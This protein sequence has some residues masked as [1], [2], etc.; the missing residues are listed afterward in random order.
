M[1]AASR[2][3]GHVRSVN[4][5]VLLCIAFLALTPSLIWSQAT[6]ATFHGTVI[7]PKGGA[8]PGATVTLT[9]ENTGAAKVTTTGDSGD[10]VFTFVPASVY[11][12]R[13]ELQGF[14][15]YT[16]RGILLRAGQQARQTVTLEVGAITEEV[17]VQGGV[18]LVNTVS[19]EQLQTFETQQV[20]ELPLQNRNFTRILILNAGAVPSTGSA[21]GFNMN[22]VGTNG[23]QW[24]LDGTSASGN[25][26]ANS[27]GAYEA[28]NL[29][30]IASQEGIAEV[31]VVKGAIPAEYANA[32]GGQVNVISKSGTNVWHGSVFENHRNDALNARFQR[33]SDKPALTFNQFGG[34]LGG[35]IKKDTIFV[36]GDYEGYREDE[37]AFVQGNVP[38]E[39]LRAQLLDAVPAY[40]LA[41]DAFP[42]PNEPTEPGEVVGLFQTAKPAERR[43]NHFDI[44]G[45]V[46]LTTNHRLAVTYNHGRP[47]RSTPRI[48]IDDDRTWTNRMDRVSASYTITATHWVSETRLG[49]N[50]ATQ[51]RTDGFFR[52][53]DPD[54]PEE[55]FLGARRL[56]RISTTLGFGGPDAEI[57]RSGGPAWEISQKFAYRLGRHLLK[58]GS[59]VHYVS[60]TR[61]NPEIP[62][63]FYDSLEALLENRPSDVTVTLG[64]GD[65]STRAY[66]FGFFVQDDWRV[67]P[68]LTLNAGLRYDFYSNWVSK[69]KGGTPD[70]GL[71]NPDSLSQDG[72]FTVGRFRPVS[73]PFEHD[74]LNL[75][76]RLGFAYN[77][78]GRGRTA[79]RGGFSMM[80]TRNTPEI[81][82]F[83]TAIARNVPSRFEFEP[84]LIRRFEIRYPTFN[85]EFFDS[86]LQLSE[87]SDR[88]SVFQMFDSHLESPY[89]MQYTFDIQRQLTPTLMFSTGVVGTRGVKF[90]LFRPANRV[91]R[92]TGL[93]PNPDLSEVIWTDNSQSLT[94]YAWQSS[95]TKRFSN[96][97]SFTV[98]YTWSKG[99]SNGAGDFGPWFAGENSNGVNQE[100]FDTAADRG[101]T[102]FDRT[103][104]FSAGWIY[105]VPRLER[106]GGPVV[107]HVLGSWQ[108]SGILRASTGL[109]VTVVQGSSRSGDRADFVGGAP[110]ILED[111]RNTLQYLTPAAFQLIP[112]SE[113]SGASIRPGNVGRGAF[114]EP[115]EW[116]LDFS[117]ARSFSIQGNVD[118]Q[119]RADMF[120]A[121][122]HTNLSG[123]RTSLDDT[124]FGQ[125][126][127]TRGARVIQLGARLTF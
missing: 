72:Q 88:T 115:G 76:P 59:N 29:V 109:P 10:F 107:R 100:F 91:D 23:T 112:R 97:V 126:L 71:Y 94:Y 39:A 64:N 62:S 81:A 55:L 125:L 61:S 9:D 99:L 114:R 70:A 116:N 43:D 7:D 21:Q 75:G 123:L 16:S 46:L 117:L 119:I 63:F 3:R 27:P 33:L 58:F 56:P 108:A 22:G 14:K 18:P 4:R 15:T 90:I 51:D 92:L 17:T 65:F 47:L 121:F 103:H 96:N 84:A 68:T 118:L 77:P 60:G 19:G 67:T 86:I 26:G 102:S 120:N 12:L 82:W 49:F 11:T 122:N 40:R 20:R 106:L 1:T 105:E 13:I 127:S 80:F 50:R 53:L 101:P 6:S 32:T 28:P 31:A 113:V 78:D 54:N 89:T 37:D 48:F 98:N 79:I 5:A 66:D 73:K 93:R 25:T 83:A 69:G 124:F 41:L 111:Y 52:Q 24:S 110:T 42:L 38:T 35:P 45:D 85:Q 74:P 34:S 2:L 87:E 36:F 57:N 104:F 30:D 95:L 8:V 44:R